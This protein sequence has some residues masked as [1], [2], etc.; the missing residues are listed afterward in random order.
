MVATEEIYIEKNDDD[1]CVSDAPTLIQIQKQICPLATHCQ[2]RLH[3]RLIPSAEL[4]G[5]SLQPAEEGGGAMGSAP[6]VMTRN[7]NSHWSTA[8]SKRLSL[9]A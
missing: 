8:M 6:Q 9:T 4:T 7:L 5:S 1:G 2:R 3:A